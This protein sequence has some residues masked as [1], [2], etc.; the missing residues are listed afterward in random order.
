MK[1]SAITKYGMKVA[2]EFSQGHGKAPIQIGAIAKQENISQKY[3]EQMV[4]MLKK[5]GLV[6]SIRGPRGGYL[7]AKPPSEIFLKDVFFA[8]N[9][10]MSPVECPEH[11]KHSKS[12]IDCTMCQIWEDLQDAILGVLE[13]VTLADLLNRSITPSAKRKNRT[14]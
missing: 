7:L 12:C 1:L 14:T 8:L 10:P 3:L 9:G 5:V 13:S 11:S 6:R 2:L 4:V